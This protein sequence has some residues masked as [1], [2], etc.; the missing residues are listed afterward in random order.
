MKKLLIIFTLLTCCAILRAEPRVIHTL[1]AL[2]DNKYQGIV[3]VPATLGNGQDPKNNLYWGAMYGVKSYINRQENW[4]LV[5]TQKNPKDK[6]LERVIFKHATKDV[7]IVADA[8]DGK[9]ITTTV[10]DFF[11]YAAANKK[12][13]IKVKEVTLEAGG[14]AGLVVFVGHD[15][16][17]DGAITTAEA[18]EPKQNTK[19]DAAVFACK[20]K[21]YFGTPLGKTGIRPLVLTTGLM[22]P[23]AYNLLAL[24]NAWAENKT[25]VQTHEAVAQAYN[26]Y[27]KCGIKPARNLFYT[28]Q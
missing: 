24:A 5:S 19:R 27:Q 21:Q 18:K 25:A 13:A 4:K 28:Q 12:E 14:G 8:Y 6:I 11:E 15:A 9:H 1:V 23:E 16:F 7:Y 2:C 20:S 10:K 17:M 26:K 3:P 22:A